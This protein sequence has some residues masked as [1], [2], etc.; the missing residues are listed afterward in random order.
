MKKLYF[1]VFF[2]SISFIISSLHAETSIDR[3]V[4]A[5]A[6]RLDKEKKVVLTKTKGSRR[7]PWTFH[8]KTYR[9][10][11]ISEARRLMVEIVDGVLHA[12]ND[13]EELDCSLSLCDLKVELTF[14]HLFGQYVDPLYVEKVRLKKGVL[15]YRAFDCDWEAK[16]CSKRKETYDQAVHFLQLWE[17]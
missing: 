16:C 15:D 6:V 4:R 8:F 3:A 1:F 11:D 14:D 5:Y 9:L 7:R 12:V 13:D 2:L 17:S 10:V